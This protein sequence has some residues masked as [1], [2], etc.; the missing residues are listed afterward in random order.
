MPKHNFNDIDKR[1]S[2]LENL[3][4]KRFK[5]SLFGLVFTWL[6]FSGVAYYNFFG[7]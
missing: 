4:N 5:I 7:A 6:V 2:A 1:I 3:S